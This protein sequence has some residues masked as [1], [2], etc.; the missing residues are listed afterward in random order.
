MEPIE[1]LRIVRS[2]FVVFPL[3]LAHLACTKN[4]TPANSTR[5]SI[6][7][8]ELSLI[9]AAAQRRPQA[10]AVQS[11]SLIAGRQKA[12]VAGLVTAT[13]TPTPAPIVVN[14]IMINVSGAGIPG[15]KDWIWENR[16]QSSTPPT[17]AYFDIPQG[18]GRL[19]Q[20]LII[21]GPQKSSGGGGD[22]PSDWAFFYGETTKDLLKDTDSADISL[23]RMDISAGSASGLV[24][25]RYLNSDGSG[26]TGKVDMLFV[27][28]NNR[29]SIKVSTAE[30]HGGWFS[31]FALQGIRFRYV[32]ADGTSLLGDFKSDDYGLISGGQNMAITVPASYRV[33]GCTG[34]TPRA[35]DPME[36]QLGFF[37][38][39]AG[40]KFACYDSSSGKS[41]TRLFA[42]SNASSAI[43]WAGARIPTSAEGGVVKGGTGAPNAICSGTEYQDFIKFDETTVQDSHRVLNINGPFQAVSNSYGYPSFLKG[44]SVATGIELS[45][46]YLPGV[47]GASRVTGVGIFS[48][49][50]VSTNQNNGPR[51]YEQDDGFKCNELTSLAAPFTF[52]QK[53]D[54]GQQSVILT[55]L[56]KTDFAAG[57]LQFIACPYGDTND[58]YFNSGIDFTSSGSQSTYKEL[59]L[60]GP[61]NLTSGVSCGAYKV[62]YR[63]NNTATIPDAAI[64][65]SLSSQ[66]RSGSGTAGTFYPAGSNCN[67][68]PITSASITTT[69]SSV[70]FE[71]LDST[72]GFKSL[73]I[74][75][76]TAGLYS[77]NLEIAVGS[78]SSAANSQLSI[79][80]ANYDFS[81]ALLVQG[82]CYPLS[83][84]LVNG[85]APAN[86]QATRLTLTDSGGGTFWS[87]SN[88][89]TTAIAG[90]QINFA[91]NEYQKNIFFKSSS[92]QTGS[93]NISASSLSGYASYSLA[94]PVIAGYRL[95]QNNIGVGSGMP[96]GWLT[97]SDA[98]CFAVN[99]QP[100]ASN[101]ANLRISASATVNVSSV[102]SLTF[103]STP[104][105][106][107]GASTFSATIPAN[108]SS[109]MQF[110]AARK[111]GKTT[112]EA[113]ATDSSVTAHTTSFYVRPETISVNLG[114]GPYIPGGC[115]Q[116]NFA[117]SSA[118]PA[119]QSINFYTVNSTNLVSSVS[120]SWFFSEDTCTY[121][122]SNG[123]S[124]GPAPGTTA[125]SAGIYV[126][127]IPDIFATNGVPLVQAQLLGISGT[128][129]LTSCTNSVCN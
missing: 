14:R 4:D 16:D 75:T 32:L 61:P 38:P 78:A 28:G 107:G 66:Q 80:E 97:S 111:A 77:R 87:D 125:G 24:S 65:F 102:D 12:M 98:S 52:Q 39:G 69:A 23:T 88:C 51:D 3:L 11:S 71:Y 44:R 89:A 90:A 100:Y 40:G 54:A 114:G 42:T 43:P 1:R 26:P 25:G 72:P 127:F 2:L 53:V 41:L 20:I 34:C 68:T 92:T 128:T 116:V 86:N 103:S 31:F 30:I 76:S 21:A 37:G 62:E 9:H 99:V 118:L 122:A 123:Y 126:R 35:M 112:L 119:S 120:G 121:P 110:W 117:L 15:I 73:Q 6:A 109:S 55:G 104:D 85:S 5:V 108:S 45:W 22:T 58:N 10:N 91:A 7:F 63:E 49:T 83:V 8:P 84:A 113:I 94:N 18:T 124:Y 82:Y 95:N 79:R 46:K 115:Y 57:K 93:F 106:A 67:G 64:T 60:S 33:D 105:C 29:P 74:S 70:N 50:V 48:R 13:P 129:A 59:Q 27:P 36:L 96:N 17:E 47:T 56:N 19:I 81:S 101:N